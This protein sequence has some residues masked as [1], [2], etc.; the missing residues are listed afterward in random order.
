MF[1]AAGDAADENNLD[2]IINVV[3]LGESD[4][5]ALNGKTVCLLGWD[6][7]ISFDPGDPSDPTNPPYASLKGATLGLTAYNVVGVYLPNGSSDELYLEVEL[8]APA[9][10]RTYCGVNDG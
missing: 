7:D 5:A 3:P 4:L 1:E 9:S 8:L 6:S 10:V 2:K